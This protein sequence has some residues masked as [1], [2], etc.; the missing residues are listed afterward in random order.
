V[1]FTYALGQLGRAT[2]AGAT[3]SEQGREKFA[4]RV[5]EWNTVLAG[6]ST[7]ALQVGSRQPTGQPVWITPKVL[8]GG[9]AVPG[10]YMAGGD[11]CDHE[12]E[13]AARLSLENSGET[14]ELRRK[15]NEYFATTPQGLAELEELLA[16]GCYRAAAPEEAALLCVAALLRRQG[17]VEEA[18]ATL[19]EIRPWFS[20][21]RFFPVP[22][23][24]PAKEGAEVCVATLQDVKNKLEKVEDRGSDS[25]YAKMRHTILDLDPVYDALVTLTVETLGKDSVR[26]ALDTAGTVTGDYP[27]RSFPSSWKIRAKRTLARLKGVTIPKRRRGNVGRLSQ[28]ISAAI[29]DKLTGRDVS[30]ARHLVAQLN[31]SR[32]LP[33]DPRHYAQRKEKALHVQNPLHADLAVALR[34]RMGALP[35]DEGLDADTF[36]DLSEGQPKAMKARL[37]LAKR[38]PLQEQVDEGVVKSADQLS[39]LAGAVAADVGASA[40]EDSDLRRLDRTLY[41]SFRARRSLLLL[42]LA[43]Q[44][45]IDELP[46]ARP[47]MRR[48]T[49]CPD[50]PRRAAA[51]L[52]AVAL[53]GFPQTILPNP[54]ITEM[55]AML[56]K[57]PL[58]KEVAADIFDC[59]FSTPFQRAAT[60]AWRAVQGTCYARYY[61]LTDAD[62]SVESELYESCCKR[63]RVEAGS[64]SA[65]GQIIEWQQILTTHNL[66]V[67]FEELALVDVLRFDLLTMAV[68]CFKFICKSLSRLPQGV[69]HSWKLRLR[70]VKNISYALRQMLFF[71]SRLP[72]RDT[73]GLFLSRIEEVLS[74]QKVAVR[75]KLEEQVMPRLRHCLPDPIA[76]LSPPLLGWRSAKGGHPLLVGL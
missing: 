35:V 49:T 29:E 64:V 25:R 48:R 40:H 4:E 39:K 45:R 59:A 73:A 6:M 71:L 52:C 31:C 8:H 67:L 38:A 53:R 23:A 72:A 74:Q 12:V 16:T 27:F 68:K 14:G 28:V 18:R 37:R 60:T 58:T 20:T 5:A 63:A 50:A 17:G 32:G 7:G 46:W 51:E 70:A 62:F 44:V 55:K 26:P 76:S 36:R 47:I 30:F 11:L 10:A 2:R 33:G 42:N 34:S 75:D 65:N 43:S 24:K 15:L 54:F 69:P 9:F 22:A 19:E 1:G 21:L 13:M 56:D 3:V 57:V 41:K 61:D 66:A